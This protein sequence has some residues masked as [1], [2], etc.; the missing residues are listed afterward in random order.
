MKYILIL[1]IIIF[2]ILHADI[3]EGYYD[4]TEGLTG[5]EL[6]T[7]L[8]NIIKDHIEFPYSS[9]NTDVWDI[10]KVTDADPVYPDSVIL[11]YTGWK[12]NGELEFNNGDGWNREH[13]WAQSHGNFGT[14]MGAGTD[15]HHIRPCDI[16]VNSERGNKDFD[17]GGEEY[18]DPDGATGC[19]TTALTWEPRAEVKGDVAR[20]IFY[21]AVRYE[22]EE[23]EPDLEMVDYVPSAPN[24]EP[25]HGKLSTLL[26]WHI[27]DTVDDWEENRNDIIYEDYQNNRNPFIDIPEFAELIWGNVSSEKCIQAKDFN[28]H[29]YP[30]PFNPSTTISFKISRKDAKHA[31][32]VIYNLKGQKVKTLECDESLVTKAD[33]V[34]YSITWNGRDENN[35]PVSS[36][37]YFYKLCLSSDSSRKSGNYSEL[38]KMILL[39]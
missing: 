22:G 11:I 29:S 13:V 10:L 24:S 18:I 36:G 17:N 23:D 15:V 21:M 39:K 9:T 31:E 38:R 16:S 34:G 26:Q 37:I 28:L 3:P 35:R 30:N 27:E 6:K 5:D 33:G 20:M 8:N 32:I 19:Y 12:K 25:F 1:L 7:A 14:S 4:G 2:G